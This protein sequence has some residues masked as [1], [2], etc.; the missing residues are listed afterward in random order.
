MSFVVMDPD[1]MV[2]AETA[3]DDI[4]AGRMVI[5]VDDEDRENEGDL[6]MAAEKVTP[7]AINFMAKEGR[8]LICLSLTGDRIER[9]GLP[10]MAVNNQS[11]YH[12]AFTVSIEAREGVSTGISAADRARTVQVAID[13][14]STASDLV[15]PGHIFPLKAR[16]G[17]VLVRTG[18]TEGS[19]DLARLAGLKP[20]GVI[21]EIMNDDGT[22][23]RLPD[24]K[25]FAEQHELHI[26]TIADLIQ[27]R[28]R[29]ERLVERVM[30]AVLP[31]PGL[32]DF[33]A[34][35]YRSRTPNGGLHMALWK[36]DITNPSLVRIQASDP[37]GDVFKA[38]SSD[39]AA[40]LDAAVCQI[41]DEGS[42]LFVYMN[43]YGGRSEEALLHMIRGHL[44]PLAGQ[45][46]TPEVRANP[47]TGFRDFG[48]GAQI[49]VDMGVRQLRLLT[50]NPRKIVGLEGYG[51]EVVER[52]PIQVTPT[53]QN[54]SFLEA[55][56]EQLGHLISLSAES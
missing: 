43:I 25:V 18:Q 53:E 32:G 14:S 47:N 56:R 42:G 31:I 6:T 9:L 29:N 33:N 4:R 13:S 51:L 7:D 36:G 22:M 26:V 44:Q 39:A 40:Q 45:A 8:G 48:T 35:I 12:T 34:R 23:A 21:C 54:K 27:W 50:N 19:V 20:A 28:L 46:E 5:L 24:L 52:V 10:M 55:R 15:T 16:D 11:P 3:I 38:G 41:A 37:V 30:D 17:G 2:R 1:P 49:L